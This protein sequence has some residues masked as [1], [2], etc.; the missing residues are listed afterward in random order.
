MKI[1]K[2]VIKPNKSPIEFPEDEK[3]IFIIKQIEKVF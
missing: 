1:S 3:V 2:F